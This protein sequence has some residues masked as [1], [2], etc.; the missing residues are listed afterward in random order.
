[1]NKYTS[2]YSTLEFVLSSDVSVADK[3]NAMQVFVQMTL[4]KSNGNIFDVKVAAETGDYPAVEVGD[5]IL[6]SWNQDDK[7]WVVSHIVKI[8]ATHW[9]PEDA[10]E[11]VDFSG[12]SLFDAI[13]TSV[14]LNVKFQLE[15]ISTG[16]QEDLMVDEYEQSVYYERDVERLLEERYN[17]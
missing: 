5:G 7:M 12:K 11:V 3:S 9:E 14:D 15:Q 1:M 2:A 16:I 13:A 4:S 17:D 10:D 6:L 8:P